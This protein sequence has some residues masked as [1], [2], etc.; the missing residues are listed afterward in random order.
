VCSRQLGGSFG[1]IN[2]QNS[3]GK[4][5]NSVDI[6]KEISKNTI[7]YRAIFIALYNYCITL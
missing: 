4:E 1:F 6:V 2:V 7:K 5:I 3:L